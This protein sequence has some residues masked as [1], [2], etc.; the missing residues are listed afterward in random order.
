MASALARGLVAE[1]RIPGDHIAASDPSPEARAAFQTVAPG[2][3]CGEDNRQLVAS[4]ETIVL[5]VKPQHVPHLAR[6]LSGTFTNQLLISVV[7]GLT[8][9]RLA[10][11]FGTSR[12]IRVMPNAPCLIGRGASAMAVGADA[13]SEDRQFVES[14]MSG[15][16]RVHVV[17]EELLD[18]VTG[19][20]G[21]GPAYV[22]LFIEALSDGGVRMGLPRATALE[23][24]AQTVAGAA[25]MIID[26]TLHPAQVKDQVASPGGTTIAGIQALEERGFRGTTMAAVVAAT[27]RSRSLGA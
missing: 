26:G 12:I 18:A 3:A 20:S 1:G 8:I 4:S 17:G 6:E 9:E 15:V 23:L 13:T 25:Q 22:A 7:A 19:L 24:A 21:S 27:E 5:A 10:T 2:A 11:H 14:M 16:G